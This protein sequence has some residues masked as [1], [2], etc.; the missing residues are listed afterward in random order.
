MINPTRY[1]IQDMFCMIN[2]TRYTIQ[3]MSCTINPIR[4]TI[5]DVLHDK[6]YTVHHTRHVLHDKSYTLHHTRHVRYLGRY[7]DFNMANTTHKSEL[8]E[9]L[10]S[11]LKS[12]FFLFIRKTKIALY[13]RYILLKLF[14]HFT[15]AS[16]PKTWVCGHL[17]D[18][19]AQYIRKWLDIPTSATLINI[20][21]PQNKFCLNIQLPS[22][23]FVQCQTVLRNA[24]KA[25]KMK[26]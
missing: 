24:L 21:L 18:V 5:Q 11:S 9:I 20:I 4:Y 17:D 6:S 8:C 23:K 14:W 13:N 25:R 10:P 22:I 3:D 12:I 1:T 16:L 7:F 19:V 15:V 2:P 26:R